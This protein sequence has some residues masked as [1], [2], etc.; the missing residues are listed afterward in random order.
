MRQ[1]DRG[2]QRW[3]EGAA[4]GGAGLGC[5]GERQE[6][7]ARYADCTWARARPLRPAWGSELHLAMSSAVKE[8]S[9]DVSEAA[10]SACAGSSAGSSSAGLSVG[11]GTASGADGTS[12]AGSGFGAATTGAGA[13]GGFEALRRAAH[14]MAAGAAGAAGAEAATGAAASPAFADGASPAIGTPEGSQAE[15]LP[16]LKSTASGLRPMITNKQDSVPARTF[17]LLLEGALLTLSRVRGPPACGIPSAEMRTP[18]ACSHQ[19]GGVRIR[20]REHA[21]KS[22]VTAGGG[23]RRRT[24]TGHEMSSD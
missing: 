8:S 20:R 17:L 22:A 3:G 9:L 7:G 23:L 5:G 15:K 11:A 6:S 12:I 16:G 14:D 1:G 24:L 10:G 19:S 13:T 4:R 21:P 18:A 2:I